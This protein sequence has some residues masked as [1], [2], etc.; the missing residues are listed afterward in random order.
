MSRKIFENNWHKEIIIK[1]TKEIISSGITY[2]IL[3]FIFLL[4]HFV[5]GIKFQ[6]QNISPL[7]EPSFFIRS[8]YSAFTFST[9]GW[10]LYEVR[11]YKLL[12]EI[13]VRAFGSRELF[14][15]IKAVL[16]IFLMYIS[17]SYI[18]PW[19]FKILNFSLSLLFNIANLVLYI[20][21]PI[22]IALIFSF[23]YLLLYKRWKSTKLE[24]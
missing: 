7:S 23:I 1:N 12:Y 16:W 20:F 5:L 17:Y 6:W 2:I 14:N 8:F 18:V 9:L 19:I 21:P 11:F 10:F 3:S 13:I 4:W 15:A 24:K 22:G